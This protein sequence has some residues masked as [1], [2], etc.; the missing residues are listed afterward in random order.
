MEE[1]VSVLH[2]ENFESKIIRLRLIDEVNEIRRKIIQTPLNL[3][4]GLILKG[5]KIFLKEKCFLQIKEN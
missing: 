4:V 3:F 2:F 1:V 5:E